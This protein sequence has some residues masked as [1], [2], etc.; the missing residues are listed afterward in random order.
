MDILEAGFFM[1]KDAAFPSTKEMSPASSKTDIP[2]FFTRVCLT[3]FNKLYN[4]YLWI[5]TQPFLVS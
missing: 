2:G 5:E 3:Q 4:G 1:R